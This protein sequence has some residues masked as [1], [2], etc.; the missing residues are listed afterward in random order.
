MTR[1]TSLIKPS[2]I[3][4][5]SQKSF[6]TAAGPRNGAA[7]N[8]AKSLGPGT[9]RPQQPPSRAPTSLGFNQ[10]TNVR[11]RANTRPKTAMGTREVEDESVQPNQPNGMKDPLSLSLPPTQLPTTTSSQAI[12]SHPREA[13]TDVSELSKCL[14]GIS[15]NN[16]PDDDSAGG[17]VVSKQGEGPLSRSS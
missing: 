13:S 2:S 1:P 11:P 3:A 10:S 9:R 14:S 4:A 17:Q 7:G 5:L 12:I 16:K 6:T 8:F 15:L